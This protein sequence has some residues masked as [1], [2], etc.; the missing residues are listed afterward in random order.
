MESSG[1]AVR[2]VSGGRLRSVFEVGML[3]HAGPETTTRPIKTTKTP[4]LKRI[5]RPPPRPGH[6]PGVGPRY[7]AL[8]QAVKGEEPILCE[9]LAPGKGSPADF[10]SPG[11]GSKSPRAG[12]RA[13]RPRGVAVSGRTTYW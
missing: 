3:R 7:A 13:P 8:L 10:E 6:G 2:Y 12:S 1:A 11:R 5:Q 9:I 4:E